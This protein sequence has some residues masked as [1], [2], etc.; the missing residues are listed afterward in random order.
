MGKS[1]RERV[2]D[3]FLRIV[4]IDSLS[5]KEDKMFKYL[6]ERLSSLPVEME[7]SPYNISEIGARS[8]NLIVRLKASSRNR[9]SIFFDSHV[10]TVEPG[11][12]IEPVTE[13]DR[14]RS[15]GNTIL[16]GDDKAGTAAM[17]IAM[18][19]I[20]G[21]GI[22]HGDIYFL[23]TSAEEIGLTGV[24][25]LDFKKI[26]ADY[27]FVLDSHGKV[28]GVAIAAPH[29]YS[30]EIRVKGKASH[31]GVAPQEGINAIKAAAKI[32]VSLPQGQLNRDTVSNVGVIEGGHAFNIVPD[33]CIIKGEFRSHNDSEI[34]RLKELL[35]SITSENMKF[36]V[37]I[38]LTFQEMYKGFSFSS[39]DGII[40]FAGEAIKS[41]GLKPRFESTAGGSNT[42]LYNQH[43]I[44]SVNLAVGMMNVHSPDEY[45][46]IDDLE[47]TVKL[48]IALVK[49]A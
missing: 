8:G 5:L 49:G 46:E 21:N 27:G 37:D 36:A 30:Y 35:S 24:H 4:R 45:I 9:K 47:N 13:N 16:G 41:I 12:G 34:V 26:K 42:N 18:E 10:D 22:E 20:I 15:K 33:L 48:I 14:I 11:V 29:H 6:E 40:K 39:D 25:H 17:I 28:G 31:A 32:V 43:K 19:E 3:E 44:D 1:L 38:T 7:F 2:I 23:F